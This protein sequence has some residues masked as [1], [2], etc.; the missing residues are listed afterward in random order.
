MLL[1]FTQTLYAY[2]IEGGIVFVGKRKTRHS[3]SRCIMTER[4][5]LSSRTLP[6]SFPSK[7][8]PAATPVEKSIPP[9]YALPLTYVRST[10]ENKSLLAK[11]KTQ[12]AA[13]YSRFFDAEAFER[14][15]GELVEE[16]MDGRDKSQK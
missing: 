5:T 14:W 10:S 11:G 7:S 9:Q 6:V 3:T 12:V 8:A 2:F 13:P 15:V 1:T 4:I 16:G